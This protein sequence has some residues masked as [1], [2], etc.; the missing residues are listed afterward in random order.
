MLTSPEPFSREEK[1]AGSFVCRETGDRAVVPSYV[2][3]PISV[4]GSGGAA[5]VS[6]APAGTSGSASAGP[7]GAPPAAA[8]AEVAGSRASI[9]Q[10]VRIVTMADQA[11]VGPE[12][13]LSTMNAG[14]SRPP[15]GPDQLV[16][17]PPVPVDAL[18]VTH[19]FY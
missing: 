8:P 14:S 9:P 16:Q 5:E 12:L 18:S 11:P 1:A 3:P 19:Q 10:K 2:P 6:A 15:A 13:M 17:A 4:G 7:G